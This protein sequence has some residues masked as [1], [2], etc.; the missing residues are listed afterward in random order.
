MEL[1][2]IRNFHHCR[3]LGMERDG[4]FDPKL[5]SLTTRPHEFERVGV[6]VIVHYNTIMNI[7]IYGNPTYHNE[8]SID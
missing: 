2:V 6:K 4:A 5:N 7:N 3:P 8:K 1:A